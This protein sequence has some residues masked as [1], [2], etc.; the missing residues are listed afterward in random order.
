M[1]FGKDVGGPEA[2][3]PVLAFSSK[4]PPRAASCDRNLSAAS[5]PKQSRVPMASCL[6]ARFSMDVKS[7][8]LPMPLL[9]DSSARASAAFAVVADVGGDGN[10]IAVVA[11]AV[12]AGVAPDGASVVNTA[13]GD[14]GASVLEEAVY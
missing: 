8:A 12:V 10:G 4:L 3:T 2:A 5:A 11:A 7:F 14:V 9:R 1:R 13:V 6:F